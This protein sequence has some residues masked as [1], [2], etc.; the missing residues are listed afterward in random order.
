VDNGFPN[1]VNVLNR[2][3]RSLSDEISFSAFEAQA[4]LHLG[5]EET[6]SV[7]ANRKN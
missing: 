3:S 5:D 1:P 4:F 6:D 7:C 2:Q